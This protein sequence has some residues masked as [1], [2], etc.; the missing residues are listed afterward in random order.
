MAE[1]FRASRPVLQKC[2]KHADQVAVALIHRT[3]EGWI[4]LCRGCAEK[5]RQAA[6][7]QS[8]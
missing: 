3:K 4:L 5:A 2:T 6:R 8:R 1:R 7:L